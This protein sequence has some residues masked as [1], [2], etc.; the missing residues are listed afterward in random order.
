MGGDQLPEVERQGCGQDRDHR[1]EAGPRQEEQDVVLHHGRLDGRQQ[2]PTGT[3]ALGPAW[4]IQGGAKPKAM[5]G[6]S[7]SLT[8]CVAY[9]P[10][11]SD[12]ESLT[13]CVAYSPFPSDRDPISCSCPQHHC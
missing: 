11:L 4:L 12:S 9:G 2:E 6:L 3:T 8:G 1:S 7:E 5:K 13:G 10:S